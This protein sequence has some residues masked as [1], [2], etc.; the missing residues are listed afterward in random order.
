VD[1]IFTKPASTYVLSDFR[2]LRMVLAPKHWQACKLPVKLSWRGVKF[3]KSNLNNV[4][5][6][7]KGVYSFVVK[8][9]IANHPNCAYLLYVGKAQEQALRD[10]FA[11]YFDEKAKGDDSRRPHITEMLLK[12]DGFLWLYLFTA[13][14]GIGE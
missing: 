14:V 9:E 2:V 7:A 6:N 10:R 11:Q 1:D 8:P 4:P 12:W 13:L 3:D 5:K